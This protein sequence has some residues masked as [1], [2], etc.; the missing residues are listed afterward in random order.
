MLVFY[1]NANLHMDMVKSTNLKCI[2]WCQ[3]YGT[4]PLVIQLSVYMVGK[5]FSPSATH[6]EI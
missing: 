6:G 5:G 1:G 3:C 4:A 2:V